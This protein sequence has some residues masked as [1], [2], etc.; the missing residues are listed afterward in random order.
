MARGTTFRTWDD[1]FIPGTRVLRNK[2][3]GPGKPHGETDPEKLR[4]MEEAI[5]AVRIREL[6]E[7]P[8]KGRFDYDHMKAIHRVAF[9]DVYEWAGQERVAPTGAFMVKDGHSYYPAGPSLTEAAETQYARLASKDHL[10]GLQL[11]DF[12]NEL[13]ESWGEVN[14]IH[15]AR[16]GNTRTQFVFYSQLAEQAGYQIDAV[17]FAPGAA[18]RDEF[19]AARFHS[20]DTGRNNRLAAVLSQTIIP[21]VSNTAST[22]C[23]L[24]F[25]SPA[26]DVTSVQATITVEPGTPPRSRG[27][28][29]RPPEAGR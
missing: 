10:R 2:F 8:I 14:V 27:G 11:D 13:A 25:P 12:V 23:P 15:F 29:R 6:H 28:D 9:G 1:Y 4:T 3:T 17:R 5:T 19:V 7:N 16:E 22:S 26:T 21:L 24:S 18:L 20:Q